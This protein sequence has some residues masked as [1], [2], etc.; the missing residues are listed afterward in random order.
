MQLAAGF[1]GLGEETP[2]ELDQLVMDVDFFSG[3]ALTKAL[4]PEWL[5]K[6]SGHVVQ[7]SSVQG[8][9]RSGGHSMPIS[10]GF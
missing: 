7:I 5:E 8:V 3:V 10:A 1:R 9:G 2:L 6:G 4:L